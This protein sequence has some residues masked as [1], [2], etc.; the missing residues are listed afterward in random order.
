LGYA[1]ENEANFIG[2]LAC[3]HNKDLFYQ[4]AGY[5]FALRYCLQEMSRR[6]IDCYKNTVK[7]IH[8][9]ILKNFQETSEFWKAYNNPLEPL[10]KNFYNNFLKANNQE[11]GIE[12]YSYFLALLVDYLHNK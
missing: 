4:Y 2:F 1:A 11:K 10:I 5:A 12:S 3:I 6:D 9:G 8:P 7:S